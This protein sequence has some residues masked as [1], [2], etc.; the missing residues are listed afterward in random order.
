MNP[1]TWR[2]S[3]FSNDQGACVEVASTLAAVRDSKNG[4][5]PS[6]CFGRHQ[7]GAFIG[8]VKQGRLG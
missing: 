4:A 6:L 5:G 1:T 3:S 2:K 7:L 8:A